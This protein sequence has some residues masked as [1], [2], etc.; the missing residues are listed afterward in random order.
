MKPFATERDEHLHM[1][2]VYHTAADASPHVLWRN[3]LR[4]WAMKYEGLANPPRQP[5]QIDL[6]G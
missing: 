4:Q 2:A 6:F 1:A 3:Q 5:E